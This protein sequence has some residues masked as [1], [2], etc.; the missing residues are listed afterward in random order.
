MHGIFTTNLPSKSTIDVGEYTTPMDPMA[1][2]YDMVAFDWNTDTRTAS[3]ELIMG[4]DITVTHQN[5]SYS[6]LFC[7][8]NLRFA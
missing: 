3:F 1:H 4:L 7:F 5:S 8:Q 6:S 2:E